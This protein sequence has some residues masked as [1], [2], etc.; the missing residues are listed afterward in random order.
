MNIYPN[1][2]ENMNEE[3]WEFFAMDF[4]N[5]Q[6]Y[7]ILQSPSRGADGGLDGL[8]EIDNTKYLVSCKHFIISNKSVGTSDENNIIDRIVQHNAKGFIGFYSTLPSSSLLERFNSISTNSNYLIVYYDKDII[9]DY[10]PRID[11]YI[12]QKYGLPNN[13]KYMMNVHESN[14][15]PLKCMEC[16]IDILDNDRINISRVQISINEDEKLEFLYGCKYCLPD[17]EIGW[18][19]INEALHLDRLNSWNRFVED[20]LINYSVSPIFYK[21]KNEFDTKIQQRIFPSN[22]GKHPLSLI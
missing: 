11:S 15:Q 14:Y 8:V 21:N 2:F 22:Y 7:Q 13:I 4:L 20:K 16:N 10:L 9:S 19:E 12:L 1:F 18:L 6:G 5:F 3:E 17:G